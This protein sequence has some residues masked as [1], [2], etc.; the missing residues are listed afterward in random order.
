MKLSNTSLWFGTNLVCLIWSNVCDRRSPRIEFH[1]GKAWYA[2]GLLRGLCCNTARWLGIHLSSQPPPPLQTLQP[3]SVSPDSYRAAS[4]TKPC[5]SLSAHNVY[6][7]HLSTLGATLAHN[8]AVGF[9]TRIKPDKKADQTPRV[10]PICHNGKF[11]GQHTVATHTETRV[12]S[13]RTTC[14]IADL[15]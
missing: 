8:S 11:V 13:R 15:V 1:L 12:Y 7:P 3:C 14:Q 6:V 10:C 2:M 4:C 5:F 9:P